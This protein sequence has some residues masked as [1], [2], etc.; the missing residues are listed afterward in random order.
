MGS[1][2]GALRAPWGVKRFTGCGISVFRA[3]V[4]LQQLK[5]GH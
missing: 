3:E 5:A 4:P 2:T 1:P